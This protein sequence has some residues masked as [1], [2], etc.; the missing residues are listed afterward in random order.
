MQYTHLSW[1]E[2]VSS[3]KAWITFVDFDENC[4]L[5]IKVRERGK[6]LELNSGICQHVN[7]THLLQ[8]VETVTNIVKTEVSKFCRSVEGRRPKKTRICNG[9]A[10]RKGGGGGPVLKLKFQP[11]LKKIQAVQFNSKYFSKGR[12]GENGHKFF[13]NFS[14]SDFSF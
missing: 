3:I 1:L 11:W 7:N 2:K 14:Q 5:V 4:H 8:R 9:Q 13:F 6:T 10:D 12:T